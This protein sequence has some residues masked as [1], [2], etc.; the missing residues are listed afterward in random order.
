[1]TP[2]GS[3]PVGADQ[4]GRNNTPH[5]GGAGTRSNNIVGALIGHTIDGKYRLDGIVGAGGMGTVYRATRLMIG[6]A[7]AI[8]IMQSE[9]VKDDEAERFRREAQAAARL[10]HPNA[11]QIY[12]FGISPDGLV[13]LVMEL[14]D[15]ESLRAVIRTQGSLAPATAIE[16]AQQVCAALDEAHEAHIVHRDVKPD[17]II[18][19]RTARGLRVKLLD[20]GVAKLRDIAATNLTQTGS[21]VGTPHYMSPEQC[22]G[23]ELDGRSDIY[24]VGIVLYEML[25]GAVPFNSPISTA[26]IVQHVNQP[27]PPFRER[28]AGINAATEAAVRRALEKRPEARPQTAGA[29]AQELADSLNG[30]LLADEETR[31]S[32]PGAR[33][34][35]YGSQPGTDTV[36]DLTLERVAGRTPSAPGASDSG[37]T[38]TVVLS[39]PSGASAAFA[40]HSRPSV[41]GGASTTAGAGN[42]KKPLLLLI[43]IAAAIILAAGV[44]GTTAWLWQGQPETTKKQGQAGAN[45]NEE[46][47]SP[48][49]VNRRQERD[50]LDKKVAKEEPKSLSQPPTGMVRV[51]GGEFV[52]GNDGGDEYERPAHRVKVGAFFIDK[53]EVT[54]EEYAKFMR[55]SNYARAPTG[56]SG[57]SYPPGAAHHPVTGVTWDDANAYARWAGKRLPTEEEWEFAARGTQGRRYPWGDD[58]RAGLANAD[59]EGQSRRKTAEVGQFDGG[60]SPFGVFDMAGNAWEWTASPLAAYPGGRLPKQQEGDLR[61]IRGG[62]WGSSK[63]VVSG[64][65]RGGLA[66]DDTKNNTYTG[67][68]CVMDTPQ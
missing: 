45:A 36:G 64:T 5:T 54:C 15:G 66:R 8:K 6:D 48:T 19:R 23:E 12:D 31:E 39:A 17:N 37:S 26:V 55:A 62:Y 30:N 57:A 27:P 11:V 50:A 68:R 46:A 13:Y 22:L 49:D 40:P 47:A 60:A 59:A 41:A 67:F 20:F 2:T 53:Y 29:L 58:W 56:W 35:G 14:V 33:A 32:A 52:M 24:S 4:S 43:G 34:K 21:V 28:K 61:V 38:P 3:V 10:K 63:K 16:I 42:E 51:P 18:V 65:F 44:I 7:V 9:F 1:M 25:C